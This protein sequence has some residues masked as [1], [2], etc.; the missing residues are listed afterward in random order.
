M[1]RLITKENES[2][3]KDERERGSR[4][5]TL[6]LNIRPIGNGYLA[7]RL[8]IQRSA[9]IGA[10]P[11]VRQVIIKNTWKP[12]EKPEDSPSIAS[13][14]RSQSLIAENA[15]S[16]VLCPRRTDRIR[17]EQQMSAVWSKEFLPYP[18]MTTGRERGIRRSA[19][20]VIRKLS[21]GSLSGSIGKSSRTRYGTFELIHKKGQ[22]SSSDPT[23][24][25]H[26]GTLKTVTETSNSHESPPGAKGDRSTAEPPSAAEFKGRVHFSTNPLRQSQSFEGGSRSPA[27]TVSFKR[28]SSSRGRSLL[29]SLSLSKL[30][31]R[32]K[33]GG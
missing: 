3:H 20:H 26:T 24:T 13:L 32:T 19:S 10:R 12:E 23:E 14:T 22:E 5:S 9:T 27:G 6:A 8:S 31:G 33:H 25:S 18:T 17:I 15:P 21:K 16:D 30:G 4:F 7:R 11:A 29:R 1:R 28:G 2:Y